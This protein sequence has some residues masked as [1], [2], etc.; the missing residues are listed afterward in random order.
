MF[1]SGNI[2]SIPGV[3]IQGANDGW[4]SSID[5]DDVTMLDGESNL[6]DSD[7]A[8]AFEDE[9]VDTS[10][11][12]FQYPRECSS[13]EDCDFLIRVRASHEGRTLLVHRS[14]KTLLRYFCSSTGCVLQITYRKSAVNGK[15]KLSRM[16]SPVHSCQ[17][18][19]A[20]SRSTRAR[21]PLA[22]KGTLKRLIKSIPNWQSLSPKQVLCYL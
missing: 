9:I 6:S 5:E 16:S 7:N 17:P 11:N 3:Y 13:K 15:W 14:T 21:Q 4:W 1:G 8:D 22:S 2:T 18:W 19:Q 20:S 10:S 12:N